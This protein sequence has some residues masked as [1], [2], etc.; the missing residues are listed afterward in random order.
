MVKIT[1]EEKFDELIN[2]RLNP[3]KKPSRSGK[4]ANTDFAQMNM[5]LVEFFVD[6]AETCVYVTIAFVWA[7]NDFL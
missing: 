6:W 3:V 1:S 4:E 5:W 7:Y 2:K